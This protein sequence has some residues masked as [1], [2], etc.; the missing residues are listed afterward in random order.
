MRGLRCCEFV[1]EPRK[2]QQ[3]QRLVPGS[4]WRKTTTTLT[5]GQIAVKTL[6]EILVKTSVCTGAPFV[7]TYMLPTA[8]STFHFQ[9]YNL[10]QCQKVEVHGESWKAALFWIRFTRTT[11]KPT[12]RN[13]SSINKCVGQHTRNLK[14]SYYGLIIIRF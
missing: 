7:L 3:V 4:R 9:H 10:T 11:V 8:L 1:S 2:E 5:T 12:R 13:S 6:P 14:Y